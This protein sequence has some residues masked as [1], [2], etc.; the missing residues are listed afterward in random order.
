MEIAVAH[1]IPYAAQAT[2]GNW[3]DFVKKAEKAHNT[4][5]PSVLVVLS[6]CVLFWG[7]PTSSPVAI[8]KAAIDTCFWPLYEVEDGNYK[9]NYK[10]P[11][12]L[13]ITEFIKTQSRFRHLL[14][15]EYKDIVDNIQS[16]I[17]RDWAKVLKLTGECG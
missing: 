8:T 1:D 12:K 16:H 5:G 6:P 2:I 9:L 11:Q 17:D 4:R 13:P 3:I 15:P 14:K 10:P 7:I